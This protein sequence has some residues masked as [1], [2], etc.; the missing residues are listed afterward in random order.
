ME[1]F[2]DHLRKLFDNQGKGTTH[3]EKVIGNR[4][5][6]K[7]FSEFWLKCHDELMLVA[8]HSLYRYIEDSEPSKEEMLAFKKGLS[9]VALF[10]GQCNTEIENETK[11]ELLKKI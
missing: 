3:C 11:N 10:I 8:V 5:N 9:S 6:R 4:T 1:T 7:R 2:E